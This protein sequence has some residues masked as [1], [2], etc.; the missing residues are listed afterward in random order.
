MSSPPSP[1]EVAAGIFEALNRRD[2][3]SVA[4][5]QDDDIV[6]GRLVDNTIYY[7]G[8]SFARQIGILPSEGSRGDRA[9]TA[10]FN[11]RTDLRARLPLPSRAR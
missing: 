4:R 1:A 6:G 3:D 7:D 9:L 2:Q 10:A 5:L 8:L 11:A